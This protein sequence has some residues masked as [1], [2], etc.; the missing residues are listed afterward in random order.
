MADA[1]P[2]RQVQGFETETDLSAAE[3][4]EERVVGDASWLHAAA[5]V[6]GA[7]MGTGVL[8]LPHAFQNRGWVWGLG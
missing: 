7:I 3:T 4:G 6:V 2:Y 8:G 5:L 1:G